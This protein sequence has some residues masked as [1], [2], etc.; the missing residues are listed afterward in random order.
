MDHRQQLL[1]TSVLA[2]AAAA[3]GACGGNDAA[4]V[5]TSGGGAT[6]SA[7]GGGGA[8]GGGAPTGGSG[9]EGGSSDECAQDQ[10]CDKG[11][12]CEQHR[13]IPA[14]CA[15]DAKDGDETDL[16]CG[17][18]ACLPCGNGKGCLA[19]TDCDSL[20]CDPKGICSACAG[21]GDCVAAEGTYCLGGACVP[22]KQ[23]GA[24]CAQHEECT[25]GFCPAGDK[26]CC[27]SN[28][29]GVCEACRAKVTGAQDGE[30]K[31]VKAGTD[32]DAEC[33]KQ[34][35]STCGANGSGCNGDALA[36]GCKLYPEGTVCAPAACQNGASS[37]ALKCDGKGAC[38][39]VPPTSCA[40]YACDEQGKLCLAS[41]SKDGHCAAGH[42]CTSGK[43]VP[44]KAGGDG[45]AAG[46][47]CQ[48]GFC[49]GGDGVCCDAACDGKCMACLA[50]KT[51]G[52]NGICGYV[53]AG[54]D[55]DKECGSLQ[56]CDGKGTCKLL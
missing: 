15:N 51:G 20:F 48:S 36:S 18:P 39:D 34:D 56:A 24:A 28:C 17:G 2:A 25:S 7:A 6:T 37:A 29:D 40:P 41:C 35:G 30:C 43:C 3:A 49:P 26:V 53:A 47:Q 38:L 52:K 32:P 13:C 10:E 5:A 27:E 21:H 19:A 9:G 45:C 33:P 1:L 12:V 14:T 54:T 46:G 50:S 4:F 23:D 11:E 55:P 44:K 22:R 31:P 16:D 42:Y 8:G